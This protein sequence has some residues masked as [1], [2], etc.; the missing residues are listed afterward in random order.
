MSTLKHV[1]Q[2]ADPEAHDPA[3]TISDAAVR[4]D[5]AAIVEAYPAATM[6]RARWLGMAAASAAVVAG[7]GAV[8]MHSLAPVRVQMDPSATSAGTTTNTP[9]DPDQD[10][11]YS[12]EAPRKVAPPV[13]SG[14]FS[15]STQTVK[16]GAGNIV[17]QDMQPSAQQAVR[18][19]QRNLKK[20]KEYTVLYFRTDNKGTAFRG[21]VLR[22]D[23]PQLAS[24]RLADAKTTELEKTRSVS[25][26]HTASVDI[27]L[28]NKKSWQR[29][30]EDPQSVPSLCVGDGVCDG[31]DEE[32]AYSLSH[33]LFDAERRGYILKSL[34]KNTNWVVS[35]SNVPGAAGIKYTKKAKTEVFTGPLS[36]VVDPANGQVRYFQGDGET[37]LVH[38]DT[39]SR[40]DF[41][42]DVKTAAKTG[43]WRLKEPNSSGDTCT[44]LFNAKTMY[45]ECVR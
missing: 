43:V 4:A 13:K 39:V 37:Y 26:F 24:L 15:P 14:D 30:A 7:V 16:T 36:F 10:D 31:L 28:I 34:A 1:L 38:H 45:V 2:Q 12:F 19:V 6:S 27:A 5:V 3:R 40:S 22:D 32:M 8:T 42:E 17:V 35:T 44:N 25:V 33:H 9:F 18:L 29:L 23:N 20:P 21:K 11:Q 41:S